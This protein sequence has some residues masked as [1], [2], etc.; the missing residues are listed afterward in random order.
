MLRQRLGDA[1]HSTEKF[2]VDGFFK[3]QKV[4]ISK[5]IDIPKGSIRA[6]P[7]LLS[8]QLV[9]AYFQEYHLLFPVLHRLSFLGLYQKLVNDDGA[10]ASTLRDHEV[11]QLFL[12]FA[13]A[14]QH[15]EV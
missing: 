9:Q 12:V 15:L 13:T 3:G 6:P 4:V 7:T 8:D 10:A 1:G 11:A 14:H 2:E 5:D